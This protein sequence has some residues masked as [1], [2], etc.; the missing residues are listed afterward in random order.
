MGQELARF[1]P[2]WN[3]ITD[4]DGTKCPADKGTS[5]VSARWEPDDAGGHP[6]ERQPGS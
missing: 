1:K 2:E 6:A 4:G 5:A 3:T